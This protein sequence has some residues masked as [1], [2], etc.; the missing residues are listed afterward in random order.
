LSASTL[1][2][3]SKSDFNYDD[4]RIATS[5]IIYPQPLGL[6]V[7]YNWGTGPEYNPATKFIDQKGLN[8][9]YALLNYRQPF[10]RNV[11]VHPYLRFQYYSGGKKQ[12]L[13]ARKYLVREGD[14]GIEFQLGKYFEPTLQYQYGD[15]TFEDGAKPNNRQKG[16]LLRLQLQFNY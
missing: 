10:P 12:E 3:P 11:V 9:G 16:S 8:G 1:A 15:R 7:E 4:R 6:Q 2:I 14:L 13:D 5:L